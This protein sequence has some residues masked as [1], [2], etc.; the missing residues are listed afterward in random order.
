[1]RP[2]HRAQKLE[3]NDAFKNGSAAEIDEIATYLP[4]GYPIEIRR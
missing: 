3:K 2:C 1:M 4:F